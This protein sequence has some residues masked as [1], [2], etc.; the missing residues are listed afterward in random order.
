M[1]N[2]KIM[3]TLAAQNNLTT[4]KSWNDLTTSE[5]IYNVIA[6]LIVLSLIFWAWSRAYK[7]S[8]KTPDS[9]AIHFLFASVDPVLYLIFSYG[10]DGMC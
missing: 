2:K 9:R 3:L 6:V 8:Q 1:Y 10:I 5:K 7:C 4:N